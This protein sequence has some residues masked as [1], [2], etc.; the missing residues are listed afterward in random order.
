MSE[1]PHRGISLLPPEL[2]RVLQP[3]ADT[4]T[5]EARKQ[6]IID[7]EEQISLR[8]IA[9]EY[10][11]NGFA[12]PCEHVKLKNFSTSLKCCLGCY[13]LFAKKDGKPVH[14]LDLVTNLQIDRE[15]QKRLKE[16]AEHS[17]RLLKGKNEYFETAYQIQKEEKQNMMSKGW[18][19][20]IMKPLSNECTEY[21]NETQ[22]VKA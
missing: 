20:F 4:V 22:F 13:G 10:L 6:N 18:S 7:K 14:V 1:P 2:Y 11:R 16:E 5:A 12:I 17:R 15:M 21:I 9:F 8:S 3:L 19:G